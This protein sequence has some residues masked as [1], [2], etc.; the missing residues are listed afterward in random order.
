M[1]TFAAAAAA[2]EAP[3]ALRSSTTADAGSDSES[4]W[5]CFWSLLVGSLVFLLAS[6]P[7]VAGREASRAGLEKSRIFRRL[8][9][10][11]EEGSAS[12][13]LRSLHHRRRRVSLGAAPAAPAEKTS[14]T[15]VPREP[16]LEEVA[17]L[18][19][20]GDDEGLVGLL[21]SAP[22]VSA[23]G[24]ASRR[25][26]LTPAC[27]RLA[28]RRIALS[29]LPAPLIDRLGLGEP[30]PHSSVDAVQEALRIRALSRAAASDG[31]AATLESA[32]E[33]FAELQSAGGIADLV[34]VE[35][36]AL[37]CLRAQRPGPVADLLIY[38]ED[39]GFCPT[40]ALYAAYISSCGLTGAV[41]RGL[42]VFERMCDDLAGKPGA[43]TLGYESAINMCAQ[44]GQAARAFTLMEAAVDRGLRL[45]PGVLAPLLIVA[46]QSGRED[47]VER[48]ARAA[49][50]AV[51][52]SGAA[53]RSLE[54]ACELL[55]RR[56]SADSS[57]TAAVAKVRR[58]LALRRECS[59]APAPAKS[60]AARPRSRNGAAADANADADAD[61]GGAGASARGSS[62]ASSR[63]V[64]D[65]EV[66]SKRLRAASDRFALGRAASI[67]TAA[68]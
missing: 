38:A 20:R 63:G 1:S 16:L 36:L 47:L 19:A 64:C 66:G 8:A 9:R 59:P 33:A 67:L 13:P 37:A 51:S 54:R 2:A 62:A 68:A 46:V 23:G 50:E 14:E 32:L 26:A 28:L 31:G 10:N 17:I 6:L 41:G 60:L 24:A 12:P 18:A 43:L 49:R 29:R 35:C 44:N 11:H 61:A 42:A 3:E 5:F 22:R 15:V 4:I 25:L 21:A 48:A 39:Q 65:L 45:G 40:P 55:L 53:A 52:V 58:A 56:S 30:N 57:A 7:F 34:T 27:M